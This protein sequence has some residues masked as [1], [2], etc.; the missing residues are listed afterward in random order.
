MPLK[1]AGGARPLAGFVARRLGTALLLLFLLSLLVYGL[2]F[3]A[4]GDIARNLLGTRNATP[5]ALAQVRAQYHLDE[6]F[7]RQYW[8]WLSGLLGGDLGTSV[9][10]G[11]PV[12]SVLA[13]RLGLTAALCS[14]A[15]GLSVLVGVPAGSP[16]RCGAAGWRTGCWSA[17]RWSA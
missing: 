1:G 12:S 10:T 8:R 14:L 17:A 11:E 16:P 6:P 9:R 5:E 13:E 3:L 15:F 2:V 4:P 7:L